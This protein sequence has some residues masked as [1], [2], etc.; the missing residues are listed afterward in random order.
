LMSMATMCKSFPLLLSFS[1]HLSC[2]TTTEMLRGY[3]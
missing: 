1:H 2:H 3:Q